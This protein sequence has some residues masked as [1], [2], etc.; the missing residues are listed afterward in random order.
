M[1][2]NV[3][4]NNTNNT[5]PQQPARGFAIASMVLGIVG[6]IAWCLPLVGYPVTIIGLILGIVALTKGARGMATAGVIMCSIT[7]VMT[8]INSILGAVLA[9]QDYL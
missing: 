5:T 3:S 9:V 8:L 6:F 4:F 1:D 7:L 2:S